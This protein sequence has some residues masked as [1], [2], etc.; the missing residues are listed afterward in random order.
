MPSNKV[1]TKLNK[2][3][4]F[5]LLKIFDEEAEKSMR[6]VAVGGTAM[7][8]LDLKPSTRDIDFTVP[9][10]DKSEFY[11]IRNT[12]P[13][14]YKIDVWTNG[15]I[16]C[17]TLPPDYLDRSRDIASYKYIQLKALHPVDIVVSKI[18][19]ME[20]H[21]IEDIRECIKKCGISMDEVR[22]R[23]ATVTFAPRQEDYQYQVRIALEMFFGEPKSK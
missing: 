1:E 7:T 9:S 19:R 8:L 6:L 2:N 5:D 20:P 17:V 3:E 18:A 12:I 14:G 23:A 11:R 15:G 21:D 16:F 10:D 4:L 13:H 22:T